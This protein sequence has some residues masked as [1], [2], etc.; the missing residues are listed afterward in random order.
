MPHSLLL[1]L[2]CCLEYPCLQFLVKNLQFFQNPFWAPPLPCR[3]QALTSKA[4]QK[5][6]EMAK[7]FVFLSS[8]KLEIL[9]DGSGIKYPSIPIT[10]FIQW[11]ALRIISSYHSQEGSYL[12]WFP[13]PEQGFSKWLFRQVRGNPTSH[14]AFCDLIHEASYKLWL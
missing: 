3:C 9:A 7:L 8:S 5:C 12:L 14:P 1:K 10:P 13:K 6:Q 4:G 11:M 2:F